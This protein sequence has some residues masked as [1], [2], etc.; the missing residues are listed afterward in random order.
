MLMMS[1]WHNGSERKRLETLLQGTDIP[2]PLVLDCS[3]GLL[4]SKRVRTD[5]SATTA[6]RRSKKRTMSKTSSRSPAWRNDSLEDLRRRRAGSPPTDVG[7][8]TSQ[9]STDSPSSANTSFA[10]PRD[11]D[12]PTPPLSDK[13]RPSH[14]S[15]Q[16][17][18]SGDVPIYEKGTIGFN[19]T[20][21][22]AKTMEAVET[23]AHISKDILEG[24]VLFSESREGWWMYVS[25]M[26][27]VVV[28]L[29][30]GYIG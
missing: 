20:G 13:H 27:A 29:L 1:S 11:R 16:R 7:D 2:A 21:P 14:T 3:G 22:M 15:R 19:E 6:R 5:T 18:D 26:C 12:P 28:A 23:G 24:V 10:K 30:M 25:V 9:T 17:R 8:D 4:S